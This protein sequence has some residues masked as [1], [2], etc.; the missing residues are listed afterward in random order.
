MED[1]IDGAQNQEVDQQLGQINYNIENISSNSDNTGKT[2]S[3]GSDHYEQKIGNNFRNTGALD[4]M[5]DG[6]EG[7][8]EYKVPDTG[9]VGDD[10]TKDLALAGKTQ[11]Y[12]DRLYSTS[13]VIIEGPVIKQKKKSID[14][15]TTTKASKLD[16]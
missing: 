5:E 14:Q 3:G 6:E 8:Q 16:E 11:G 12:R 1:Y 13:G 2:K 7:Y 10:L 15:N 4:D 9:I